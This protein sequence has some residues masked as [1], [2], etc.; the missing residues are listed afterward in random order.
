VLAAAA[1]VDVTI[2]PPRITVRWRPD[3]TAVSRTAL[4]QRYDLRDGEATDARTWRYE[5]GN[6]SRDNIGALV[7]DPAVEDTGNIDREALS[8]PDADVRITLRRVSYPFSRYLEGPADLAL[9]QSSL[10]LWL[11]GGAMLWAARSAGAERRRHTA[12]AVLLVVAAA[13]WLAPIS[14]TLVQMGDANQVSESRYDFERYAGVG[15]IRFEAHLSYAILG[16]LDRLFGRTDDAPRA[17][18]IVLARAAT[19]W[20]LLCALSVGVLERWSPF[21]LRY[22]GL[23][24]L[25][26]ATLLYFGWREVGYLA[27]NVAVFP[28]LVHGLQGRRW[29]L[30]TASALSG[31]GAALHGLGL[32]SLAGVLFAA[33]QARAGLSDRMVQ[34]LRVATWGTAAYVGW[35]AIYL[36]VLKLP[37]D[38]GHA[39]YFPWRPLFADELL[40]GRINAAI[41]SA[42][43]AR[44]LWWTGWV[45][46]APLLALAV[47]LWRRYA[48]EVRTALVYSLPS[49]VFVVAFWPIQGLGEE[50]DLVFAAFPAV[51]A[52]IYVCALDVRRTAIAAALL[53]AAHYA[54]WYVVLDPQFVNIPR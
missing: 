4:E 48:P 52:L 37:I 9:L 45:V 35:V 5:A 38:V 17:A 21:V 16:Q 20:F 15:F 30:E 2:T 50:M 12:I 19:V 36:I 18:Q 13:G 25:A 28:W 11:A 43:G 47:S 51:Y 42:T 8:I 44:D 7:R 27:L 26:P 23:V 39:Q 10:W 3:V 29:R 6:G 33:F 22:L 34:A 41:F 24:L 53:A 32:V 14:P 31:L 49:F 1:L 46:G 54:F 40:E